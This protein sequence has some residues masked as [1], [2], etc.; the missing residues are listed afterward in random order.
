MKQV[1]QGSILILLVTMLL[2]FLTKIE[3]LDIP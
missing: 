3:G 1:R 2:C